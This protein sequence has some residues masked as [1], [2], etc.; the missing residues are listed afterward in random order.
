MSLKQA[1]KNKRR[2]NR[3]KNKSTSSRL[4]SPAP[5]QDLIDDLGPRLIEYIQSEQKYMDIFKSLQRGQVYLVAT[6]GPNTQHVILSEQEYLGLMPQRDREALSTRFS[7][8]TVEKVVAYTED[9][10]GFMSYFFT[11][12][13]LL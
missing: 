12:D 1:E 5:S 10:T 6:E 2:Q 7:L 13:E 8:L 3:K 4:V 11:D 9:D